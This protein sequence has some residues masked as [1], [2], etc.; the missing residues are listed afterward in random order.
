M[1]W[2]PVC[3]SEYRDGFYKCAD[4]G[5]ELIDSLPNEEPEIITPDESYFNY[6]EIINPTLLISATDEIQ[7]KIIKNILLENDIKCYNKD[8][9][10]GTYLKVCFGNTIYGTDIYVN[11]INFEK[12]KE[13]VNVYLSELENAEEYEPLKEKDNRS[14][15]IRKTCMRI[16]II[17]MFVVPF[18]LSLLFGS[19]LFLRNVYNNLI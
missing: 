11:E 18:V 15:F 10:C 5:V 3:K 6:N 19:F 7:C 17:V 12:A 14:F 4:C 16:I 9:G 13:L 1:P 8:I 2:C